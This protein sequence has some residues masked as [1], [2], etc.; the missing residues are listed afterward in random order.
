MA[1]TLKLPRMAPVPESHRLLKASAM[2]AYAS[3]RASSPTADDDAYDRD[4]ERG[5][6]IV[7]RHSAS[8]LYSP[9][10]NAAPRAFPMTSHASFGLLVAM[11][12]MTLFMSVVGAGMLS[13]P[14]A[15]ASAPFG[16]V[17]SSLVYV[18]L[19]MAFSADT[20]LRVHIATSL[21]TFNAL[22]F[23]ALGPWFCHVVSLST[24]LAVF[25]ACVGCLEI[26][27]DLAPFLLELVGLP[28]SQ[29]APTI[30]L[31]VFVAI[32]YPLTL[33][34]KLTA[35]RFSS[36]IGFSAAP[37]RCDRA[38]DRVQPVV[39]TTAH[40]MS[41]FNYAF[42]MHLNVIPL[43]DN[44]RQATHESRHTPGGS[45]IYPDA[46][47]V[48]TRIVFA[49]ST[50][51]ILMYTLFGYNAHAMYGDA[52]NGNILLNLEGEALMN[53]PRVAVLA[54]IL[55]SF[56]L[57]YHPLLMLCE[58]FT[59]HIVYQQH[60]NS[61]TVHAASRP[62]RAIASIA[63]MGL[64]LFVAA[65]MPGIQVTFSLTGASCVTL[66]CYVFPGVCYLKLVPAAPTWRK[67]LV[68]GIMVVASVVGVIATVLVCLG[69]AF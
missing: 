3:V 13:L 1:I 26:V 43:Y 10:H 34:K 8:G 5:V 67:L 11:T 60:P 63:L 68:A 53:L 6:P 33:L 7:L 57:I 27:H 22:A 55:F 36:Y 21:S 54:T 49:M 56:P 48:M 17:L 28:A 35:L 65:V 50:V 52:T 40:L 23:A 46:S 16:L 58:S 44:L 59:M 39:L 61:P 64:L 45:F 19:S 12:F 69:T 18:G 51:C 32:M 25:G 62:A 37:D 4:C 15:F 31:C 29:H 24:I 42:V 30:V 20:L 41:M 2:P 47:K 38:Q 14:Y 66:I 9:T